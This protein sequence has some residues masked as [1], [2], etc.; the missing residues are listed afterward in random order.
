MKKILIVA[1]LALVC[2]NGVLAQFGTN[3]KVRDDINIDGNIKFNSKH[4]IGLGTSAGR[5]GFTDAA[6]DY[7]WAMNAYVG[8]GT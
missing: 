7:I 4:W 1:V 6:T 3:K 5:W 8:I 2:V